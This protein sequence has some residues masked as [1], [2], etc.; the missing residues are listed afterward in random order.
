MLPNLKLVVNTQ[1]SQDYSTAIEYQSN[2]QNLVPKRSLPIKA[3][4]QNASYLM[5]ALVILAHVAGM[6]WLVN[7]KSTTPVI[8]EPATPM[9]VSLVNSPS[10][11]PEIV[12]LVPTRPQPVVKKADC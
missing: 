12:P 4:K 5:L 7:P 6:A 2:I 3:D 10:P 9:M 8:K 1:Q 11:E